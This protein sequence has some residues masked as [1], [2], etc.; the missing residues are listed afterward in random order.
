MLREQLRKKRQNRAIHLW[1]ALYL[2]NFRGSEFYSR[3]DVVNY[4]K[5]TYSLPLITYFTM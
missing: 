2:L 1:L 4:G 3:R 5:L